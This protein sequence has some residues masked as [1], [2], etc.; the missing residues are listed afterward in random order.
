MDAG[1]ELFAQHE[2]LS[3][4]ESGETPAP[5]ESTAGPGEAP[6]DAPVPEP[7]PT[8]TLPVDG[9]PEEPISPAQPDIDALTAA[10]DRLSQQVAAD[11]TVI[12]R[13]QSRIESL[14]GDQVR[15]LLAPAVTEL[16]NLHAEFTESAERDYARLGLDRVRKEFTLLS[17]H[18]ETAIDL[19]GAVSLDVQVGDEFDSRLH[20]AL[21]KVPT[22][23]SSLDRTVAAVLRQ[24]FTFDPA[25]KPVLY[26]RVRVHSYDPLLEAAA[27]YPEPTAQ[28]TSEP[29]LEPIA[30]PI[31]V[32]PQDPAD[33]VPSAAASD[34]LELPFR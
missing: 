7:D 9:S 19:L 15:A 13:M 18:I 6:A 25:G 32:L 11:Q 23:D 26:A 33:P 22:G 5:E 3:V 14:Q 2:D 27:I 31:T 12:A 21:K 8:V 30:Q 16:A 24:G 28:P 4:L 29:P 1:D 34:D 10:V 20:Q 17:D